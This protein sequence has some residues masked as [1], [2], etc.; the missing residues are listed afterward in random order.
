MD[1]ITIIYLFFIFVSLYLT[2]LF[3]VI[4]LENRGT[5]FDSPT[6][7]WLPT[8]SLLV[9][10]YNAEKRLEPSLK[11]LA[12]LEYPK[13]KLDVILI[14]DGST[15]KTA[16]IAS[17]FDWVKVIHKP[18]GGKASALNYGINYAKGELIGVMDDDSYPDPNSLKKMIPFFD[19]Q[20]VG[21]VT[22]CILIKDP[23]KGWA[24]LQAIE[25]AIIIWTRKLLEYVE[26]IFVTPGPLALYRR[27]VLVKVGGFDE[28]NLTEDIEV[29]WRI[30]DNGYIVRMAADARVY[31]IPPDTLGK[32]WRQR[33]RWTVGGLQTLNKYKRHMFDPA[34]KMFGLFIIPFWM[35][36]F[37]LSLIGFGV[38]IYVLTGKGMQYLTYTGQS[39]LTGS[40]FLTLSQLNLTPSVFT[41]FGMVLTVLMFSFVI[42]GIN[43]INKVQPAKQRIKLFHPNIF[44][45]TFIYVCLFPLVLVYSLIRM[46]RG[47]KKW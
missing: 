47:Y 41:F 33:V 11:N 43:T 26:G 39:Y 8:I 35:F 23:K 24:W 13:D 22:S 21:S 3:L 28:G 6:S 20:K 32:W 31:T 4:F 37:L 1:I 34:K 2:F 14:D 15:D 17:K 12:K 19:T 16:E 25:Y 10:A 18:N 36:F 30:L 29:A 9:P 38:F 44:I 27:N 40:S 5:F 7:N 42:F 46:T 45:Y